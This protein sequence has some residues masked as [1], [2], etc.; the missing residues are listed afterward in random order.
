[1]RNPWHHNDQL[2]LERNS[3][4]RKIKLDPKNIRSVRRD[5]LI[6][7]LDKNNQVDHQVQQQQIIPVSWCGEANYDVT[8]I[9]TAI[10]SHILVLIC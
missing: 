6:V 2:K 4:E 9:Q 5:K 1:M 10:A 3:I 7:K 8:I